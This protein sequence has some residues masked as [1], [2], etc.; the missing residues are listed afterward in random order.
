MGRQYRREN[1]QTD[2]RYKRKLMC[3]YYIYMI[4][5]K[6]DYHSDLKLITEG[7]ITWEDIQVAKDTLRKQ[8]GWSKEVAVF[9]I[10]IYK[11]ENSDASK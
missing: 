5:P 4:C 11:L 9:V 2:R 6:Y 7:K 1:A 3:E 8:G 10:H